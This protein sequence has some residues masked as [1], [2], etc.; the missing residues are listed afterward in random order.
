[1][2]R[3]FRKHFKLEFF[4]LKTHK[5][6]FRLE[7]R[8]SR[9]V[10]ALLP[11][12]T[13]LPLVHLPSDLRRV[14]LV[15]QHHDGNSTLSD[16]RRPDRLPAW[17]TCWAHTRVARLLTAKSIIPTHRGHIT[18]PLVQLLHFGRIQHLC[19]TLV[20]FSFLTATFPGSVVIIMHQHTNQLNWTK[21][22]GGSIELGFTPPST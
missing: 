21:T 2:R 10:S 15:L 14:E 8:P 1:M 22:Q 7:V 13:H 3:T 17:N 11:S 4:I 16:S 18:G 9:R 6:D 20:P 19:F 12:P 5:K